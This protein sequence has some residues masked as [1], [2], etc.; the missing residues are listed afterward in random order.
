MSGNDAAKRVH[1][2]PMVASAR[3][4]PVGG[5]LFAT[6]A[7]SLHSSTSTHATVLRLDRGAQLLQHGPQPP[8]HLDRRGRRTANLGHAEARRRTVTG[9]DAHRIMKIRPWCDTLEEILLCLG[10]PRSEERPCAASSPMRPTG[11]CPT[12]QQRLDRQIRGT[13]CSDQVVGGDGYL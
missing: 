1:R 13:S 10:L 12:Q 2:G 9:V 7:S 8:R 5:K 6:L 4:R 3:K 11:A